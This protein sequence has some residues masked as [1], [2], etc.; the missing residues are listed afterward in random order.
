MHADKDAQGCGT[1]GG[2]TAAPLT[3]V[4]TSGRRVSAD[5]MGVPYTCGPHESPPPRRVVA[6][7]PD[8]SY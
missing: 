1:S 6:L 4:L 7:P 3:Q 5:S 2:G 8:C